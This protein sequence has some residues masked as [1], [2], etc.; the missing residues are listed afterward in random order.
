MAGVVWGCDG[1]E[2]VGAEGRAIGTGF[3]NTDDII[4]GCPGTTA[5]AEAKAYV[6]SRFFNGWYLPAHDALTE[7][8]NQR[9][10]VGGFTSRVYYSSSETSGT[11]VFVRHFGTGAVTLS[12]KGRTDFGARPI[13]AFDSSTPRPT[14]FTPN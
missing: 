13:R 4:D 1:N 12:S 7:L 11:D 14:S 5:A 2:L 6:G 9:A 10:V 3:I 8:Y